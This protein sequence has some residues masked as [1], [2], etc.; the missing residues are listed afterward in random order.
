MLGKRITTTSGR[1]AAWTTRPPRPSPPRVL[2]PLRLRLRSSNTRVFPQPPHL[3]NRYLHNEWYK[4]SEPVS[5]PGHLGYSPGH[6]IPL[7]R[8]DEA[9]SAAS[10]VRD[11]IDFFHPVSNPLPR[12]MPC[13]TPG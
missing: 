10:G 12:G 3:T 6:V 13:D 5:S 11:A 2:L 9:D 1:M 4:I 8:G 7:P